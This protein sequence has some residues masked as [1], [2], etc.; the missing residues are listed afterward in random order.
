[1]KYIGL[2]C[3]KKY[4]Y[5]TM[6]ATEPGDTSAQVDLPT[7]TDSWNLVILCC[8]IILPMLL[9]FCFLEKAIHIFPPEP[10]ITPE[11]NTVR[12]QY[13]LVAPAPHSVRIASQGAELPVPL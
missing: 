2:H 12:F 6:I 10:P 1:M 4:D 7:K 5:A 9:N 13:P 8:L 11:A 3:H